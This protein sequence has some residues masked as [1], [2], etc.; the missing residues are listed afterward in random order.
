[1]DQNV[2][3]SMRDK[4]ILVAMI[5]FGFLAFIT[6][7][8]AMNKDAV[9]VTLIASML[10][11]VSSIIAGLFGIYKGLPSPPTESKT[12]ETTVSQT[13]S[14]AGAGTA[15]TPPPGAVTPTSAPANQQGDSK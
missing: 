2:W 14:P 13:I 8:V 12:T 11:I 7:W 1:M 4:L 3:T 5:I 9:D 15:L 10:G 6:I